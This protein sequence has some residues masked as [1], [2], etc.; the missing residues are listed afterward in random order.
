MKIAI[1][2]GTGPQGSG[3]AK[4]FA[5]AGIDVVIGSRD[6]E[7]AAEKAQAQTHQYATRKL[8]E[9]LR[10]ESSHVNEERTAR[11][12]AQNAEISAETIHSSGVSKN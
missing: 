3:L 7:R 12:V 2:G 6:G 1:L 8:R 9:T 10:A 11:I 4:R 5:L